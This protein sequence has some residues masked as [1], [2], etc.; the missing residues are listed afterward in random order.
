MIQIN[1]NNREE[2]NNRPL[3]PHD[4]KEKWLTAL[5]SGKYVKGTGRLCGGNKY[6]CLGVLCE[7]QQRPKSLVETTTVTNS[8]YFDNMSNYISIE[9][10]LFEILREGGTFWGYTIDIIKDL[11]P[12]IGGSSLAEINDNVDS[13]DEVIEIIEKYF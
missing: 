2:F 5:R 13:F 3:L 12:S 1:I 7:V 11:F 6:C 4:I 8:Y 10:E 9:N